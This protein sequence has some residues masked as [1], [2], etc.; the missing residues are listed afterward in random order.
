MDWELR[1]IPAELRSRYLADGHWTDDTF[2]GFIER[3][4][5]A[6]PRLPFRVWSDSHPFSGTTGGLYEQ[7]LRIATG[8]AHR[9]IGV[10]DVVAY[11]L[12]N[13]A[14]AVSLIWAGFRIGAV[15]VPIIHFYGAGEVEFILKQSGAK[16]LVTV[17]RFG[18]VDHLENLRGIRDRLPALEHVV[19]VPSGTPGVELP[20]AV[21]LDALLDGA[22]FTGEP[23]ID[24]DRPAMVGYTSGTTANPKGVVH[25][26]R[27]LLFETRQLAALNAGGGRPPYVASPLAHMTGLLAANLMPVFRHEPIHL[28]DRWD[29]GR[30]LEAMEAA[31]VTLGG[32]ATIFLTSVL[33]HPAFRPEHAK[34]IHSVGLGGAPVPAAVAER[35][36]GLGIKITR[37]YGST[38]HPSITGSTQDEPQAKRNRTDGRA[39]DGVEMR[40]VDEAGRDVRAGEPGEIWSRGPD[41]FAG[42]TDPALTARVMADDGW[43]RTGDVGVLDE[44]GYLTITDRLS[45]VI[46]RGGLNL[47]A[48]EIEEALMQM[49]AVAECAVVARPDDRF[50]ERACGV[51]R[52]RPGQSAPDL[53]DVQ[54]HLGAAGLPKQ[55]WIEELRV[56]DDFPRTPSGKIRKFVVRAALRGNG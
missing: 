55:K 28:T 1:A 35:A 25:T 10:G 18:H 26:H 52:L 23:D 45:D 51:L 40:L 6:A 17:D 46:I 11:Q 34:L 50:G 19:V 21:G 53:A 27:S 22:P 49:P 29:P 16:L 14:E 20:G 2:A 47:S 41:L 31:D 38:E 15:M 4:V 42:Y 7:S 43:Y 56:V 9:G 13:W 8:L 48:A 39:L 37:A 44:E 24:P 12:P 30:A 5:G 3:E 36:E 54:A 33:D 32:G